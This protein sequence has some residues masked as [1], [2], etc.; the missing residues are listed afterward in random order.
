MIAVTRYCERSGETFWSEPVNALTNVAFVI[1]ALLIVRLHARTSQPW[2]W[3]T[4]VLAMLALLTGLGS[5]LWHTLATPWAGWADV[6]P[7]VLFINVY[8]VAFLVRV[9][10]L[11]W[12]S[13]VALFL[14]FQL[15]NAMVLAGL[16]AGLFNGSVF[17]LPALATL[18]L[19]AGYCRFSRC[20]QA[21]GLQVMGVVFTLS[22]LLRTLDTAAC[23]L[24]PL[25]THFVW[26]LLNAAV[27]YLA[28]RS[29]MD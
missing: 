25:G 6:V 10:G 16:P 29:L 11:R 2:H 13:V 5:F 24:F 9:A 20:R 28:I 8:L 23:G 1:A 21:A 3:D 12:P 4:A 19:L 26:H 27:V 17:Y 14:L 22:L 7:I 18:W 15:V